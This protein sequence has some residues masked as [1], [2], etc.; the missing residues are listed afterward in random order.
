MLSKKAIVLGGSKGIGKAIADSLRGIGCRVVAASRADVDTSDLASVETFVDF[1][2]SIDI[3]VLNTGGPPKKSFF[4]ITSDEWLKYHKQLFLGF[5]V[6]LQRLRVNPGGYIFLISSIVV[7]KPEEEMV[8]SSAYRVAFWAVLKSLTKHYSKQ[9]ITCINIAPGPI[10]TE[11]LANLV[12]D[13]EKLESGLPLG[14]AGRP[15]E[16]GNFVRAVVE[17][18]IK[19]INGSVVNFDGGLSADIF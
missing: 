19:Y 13:M 3:L 10:K 2:R 6:L 18:D 7:K 8:L 9:G 1:H 5:C 4:D 15:D 14:R 16:I 12:D 11:R 17:H